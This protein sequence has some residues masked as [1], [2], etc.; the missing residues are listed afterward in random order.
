MLAWN[1]ESWFGIWN[2]CQKT[3]GFGILYRNLVGDRPLG[4]VPHFGF[5]GMH[6]A[7]NEYMHVVLSYL[8]AVVFLNS[9]FYKIKF[10]IFIAYC[11]MVGNLLIFP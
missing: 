4:P 3:V 9:N 2:L 6:E 5:I 8:I 11:S 10:V 7:P 1:L